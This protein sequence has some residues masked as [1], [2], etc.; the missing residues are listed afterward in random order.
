ML[1]AACFIGKSCR[2]EY[3]GKPFCDT[4]RKKGGNS[5]RSGKIYDAVC[6]FAALI[7]AAKNREVMGLFTEGVYAAD[8][9]TVGIVFYHFLKNGAHVSVHTVYD[10]SYHYSLPHYEMSP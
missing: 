4:A 7:Y 9:L 5:C 3:H 2:A 6:F 1:S 8:C 10:Q